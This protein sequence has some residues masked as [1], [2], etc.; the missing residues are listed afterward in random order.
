LLKGFIV[1]LKSNGIAI[2]V[3]ELHAP[4]RVFIQRMGLL[5]VIGEDHVFPIIDAAV[6]YIEKSARLDQ[7]NEDAEWQ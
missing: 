6:H 7:N 4:V 5:E 3:A 2:Y 1:E